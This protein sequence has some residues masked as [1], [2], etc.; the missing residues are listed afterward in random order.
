[1]RVVWAARRAGVSA[2]IAAA[3]GSIALFAC[4]AYGAAVS[5]TPAITNAPNEL[6][7]DVNPSK[8]VP[9]GQSPDAI[10]FLLP[11]G[12][13]L[14]LKSR[15]AMC[16]PTQAAANACPAPAQIGFGHTVVHVTGYL[17]PGGATDVLT[18]IK[19]YLGRPVFLGD[20]ASIVFEVQLLGVTRVVQALQQN[21]GF[22]LQTKQTITARVFKPSSGPY[23]LEVQLT[24]I[25]GGL[26]LPPLVAEFVTPTWTRF[27]LQ[28]GAVLAKR[29][30]FTRTFTVPTVNGGTHTIRIPDHMLVLHYLLSDP[31]TCHSTWPFRLQVGFPAGTRTVSFEARCRKGTVPLTPPPSPS[32]PEQS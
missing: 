24:G 16:S 28:I 30:N 5:L 4:V 29:V 12:I 9:S 14:D 31:P 18:Y 15:K 3:L 17:H 6:S 7:I 1:L 21:F 32:P 26:T 8:L 25:P 22:T 27:K 11:R 10:A 20:P 13:A 23:G 2:A 19:A